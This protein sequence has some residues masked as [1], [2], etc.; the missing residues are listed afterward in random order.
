MLG[1]NQGGPAAPP[2]A[3]VP[4]SAEGGAPSPEAL[5][6]G[7]EAAPMP[8]GIGDMKV[9]SALDFIRRSKQ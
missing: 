3:G 8:P 6:P 7:A 2:G 5:M 9:A 4:P 1:L